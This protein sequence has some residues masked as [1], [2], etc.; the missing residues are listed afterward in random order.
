MRLADADR[1]PPERVTP[2]QT[3]CLVSRSIPFRR[4]LRRAIAG[5]HGALTLLASAVPAGDASNQGEPGST[6]VSAT[7]PDVLIL[8]VGEGTARAGAQAPTVVQLVSRGSRT[9]LRS[10]DAPS[11]HTVERPEDADADALGR[12]AEALMQELLQWRSGAEVRAR[13]VN[14]ARSSW[15]DGERVGLGT[16]AEQNA[17]RSMHP[18]KGSAGSGDG[19]GLGKTRTVAPAQRWQEGEAARGNRAYAKARGAPASSGLDRARTPAQASLAS[20]VKEDRPAA[21][22]RRQRAEKQSAASGGLHRGPVRLLVIGSST[23]GPQA[24]MSFFRKLPHPLGIPVLIVQHMPAA[25]TPMLAAHIGSATSWLCREASDGE[26][27]APDEARL[28]PGD[29]HMHL[30]ETADGLCL[31]LSQEPPVNF[32]RPAVDVLYRSAAQLVGRGTLAVI[33]TGMGSDGAHGAEA[34]SK[35]GGTVIVQD[36]ASSVVWGMPGAAVRTGVVKQ[37]LPLDQLAGAVALA[38]RGAR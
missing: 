1:A 3:V 30:A 4:A 22:S 29:F 25:F 19:P 13:A 16:A 34:I 10:G 11:I 28:A 36:E 6:R 31:K 21:V 26:R 8:D 24:L 9:K 2:A 33:F 18:T 12:F 7:T 23:G 27:L 35:A 17:Q 15:P 5:S 37:V 32:C 38:V 20:E 14:R